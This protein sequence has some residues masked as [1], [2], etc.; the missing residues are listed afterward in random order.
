MGLDE[1]QASG[2]TQNH[3]QDCHDTNRNNFESVCIIFLNQYYIMTCPA[4]FLILS[5][6]SEVSVM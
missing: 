4:H 2:C 5:F 1:G 6:V 3:I